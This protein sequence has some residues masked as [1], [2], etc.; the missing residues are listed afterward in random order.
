MAAS[1]S[2]FALGVGGLIILAGCGSSERP[3]ND[4]E[5]IVRSVLALLVSDGK[6]ACTDDSTQENALAVF[7]E[8]TQA[9]RAARA[10]LHWYPPQPLRPPIRVRT[11][12]LRGTELGQEQLEIQEPPVRTDPLPGF[13]QFQLGSAA[14]RLLVA[15]KNV[16]HEVELRRAWMPRG[17]QSRWW[18]A[19]RMRKDCWPLYTVS[20]PVF[21]QQIGF[22]TLRAEHWGTTY[23][24]Q[25]L[26]GQWRVTAEWSRWLY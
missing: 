11:A 3:L 4:R 14:K 13:T 25:K 24:V 17:V 22:V 19:N 5:Q 8:M 10:Q 23:A 15:E 12:D 16:E 2:R 26:G 20:N 1:A 7:R 21:D 18:V 6:P 9:P